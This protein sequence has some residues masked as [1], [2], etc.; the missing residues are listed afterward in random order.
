MD[1][2]QGFFK[3]RQWLRFKRDTTV[4]AHRF[5]WFTA[6]GLLLT[7]LGTAY[8]FQLRY[9]Q[10]RPGGE[11]YEYLTYIKAVYAV[12]NMT[13]FQ[14]T[15]ADMPPG[16]ELD[17]FAIIVPI[18]G[19]VL[20]TYLGLKVVRFIRIAFVRGERG[21]EWQEAVIEA[22][23]KNHIIICGLGRVG[24]RVTG[25]LLA[26]RQPVVGI[27]ETPSP[28]VDE[29]M[30]ADLPVILGDAE[31]EE[32]LKK[33]GIERAKTVLVCTNKD[34]VNLGIA[35]RARELNRR[36][37]I[38]LRLFE[39][40]LVNDIKTS[41]KVDAI[42]SRSAVAALSFTYAAMGGEI[43]ETFTLGER[44]YVLTRVPIGLHSPI[45]GHSIGEVAEAQDVT[46]VC[47]NSGQSLT[48][49]PDP[50]TVLQTGDNLFIFTTVD[51]LTPLIE[52]GLGQ[53]KLAPGSEGP[54]LVCGL[55]HTGYRVVTNLVGL[56]RQAVGLD[57]EP[58][59]LAVRLQE[60]NVPLKYGDLRWNSIL[61]E[62]GVQ[63]AAA[64]VVCTED[65]MVNLQIALA[66]RALNPA[67]RVVMRIFDDR[68]G[69]QLRRTFEIDAVFST[70]ALAA[71]DFVS[72]ALNRMNV[73]TVA[74][75]GIKQAIVRLQVTMS[76]LYDVPVIELQEEEGLTVLLH[77]RGEQVNIP[78]AQTT[79]LR[80]GDEI[81]VLAAPNKLDD[82]NRRN[83][84]LQELKTEGY[85]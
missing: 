37:C 72:A 40:E 56:G 5:P 13:F 21:Q 22:T 6:I 55:G 57:F 32:T 10:V 1:P 83:K 7:I 34:F 39:D 16:S 24:Y 28:L 36:A 80:V 71:P 51:R 50:A 35:F 9:N 64:L 29:L 65:D 77:A 42:I 67:L 33:A 27:E 19:L 4:F 75:E 78:P 62:A 20:F 48:I 11:D 69:E 31:N 41:F 3:S 59:R 54:I 79:R 17:I 74:I 82:L 2:T 26:Y 47:Y 25:Q 53:S 76:A 85:E 52:F 73:R 30:A 61:I 84:T 38:I 70:S 45:L 81:V 15:Y 46:V 18:I 63:R 58:S 49:E 66:A 43:I 60:L 23:V 12:V 14:L 44:S 68:L 8:I